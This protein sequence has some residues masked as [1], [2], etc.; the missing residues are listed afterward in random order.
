MVRQRLRMRVH[1]VRKR[2]VL[3]PYVLSQRHLHI[4]SYVVAVD[5]IWLNPVDDQCFR[6]VF[7]DIQRRMPW[8]EA[9]SSDDDL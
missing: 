8:V 1:G 4:L 6:L 7:G 3:V 9:F 5:S 2:L